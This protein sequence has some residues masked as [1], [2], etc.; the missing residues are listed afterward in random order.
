MKT[1]KKPMMKKMG[2]AKKA[3]P[4]MDTESLGYK[5]GGMVKPKGGKGAC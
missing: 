3:S 1:S 4:M 2:A 5:K